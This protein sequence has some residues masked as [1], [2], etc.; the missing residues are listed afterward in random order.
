MLHGFRGYPV[1]EGCVLGQMWLCLSLHPHKGKQ[2]HIQHAL[3]LLTLPPKAGRP[4]QDGRR[5]MC[6]SAPP[7]SAGMR[8]AWVLVKR[9]F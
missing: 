6:L 2:G 8:I 5:A 4:V 7:T 1:G 9:R 3:G